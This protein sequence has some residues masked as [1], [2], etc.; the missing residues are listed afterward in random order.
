MPSSA[1][2]VV[3]GEVKTCLLPSSTA[4]A[5]AEAG[6]LLALMPGRDVAWRERPS[7]IAIS[8]TTAVGVD[9]NVLMDH[10]AAQPDPVR[11]VGTVATRVVLAGGRIL[12]S[13]AHTRIVRGEDHRRRPWSHY[14][15]RKGVAEEIQLVAPDRP[16][17]SAAMVAGYHGASARADVED[18]LDLDSISRRLLG[19]IRSD[20]RLDQS[21]PVQGGTTRLR[22]TAVVGGS[23]GPDVQLHLDDETVRSVRVIVRKESDLDAV[24]RFCEDLA[25]HDWLLTVVGDALDQADHFGTVSADRL[26]ILEPLV[27]HFSG[28]WMPGA[29]T[30]AALRALW[31]DLQADPGFTRQWTTLRDRLRDNISVATLH[32]LRHKDVGME[33]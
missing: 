12:Q 30:P 27:Q 16:A 18:V 6:E 14:V 1:P 31:R 2:L 19:K 20:P 15:S 9:C 28:L 22:W 21:P 4:L 7:S 3:L 17:V 11:V 25:A 5:R 23:A 8:P 10:V 32:A 26:D 13:S 29:H 33:W 24:Q